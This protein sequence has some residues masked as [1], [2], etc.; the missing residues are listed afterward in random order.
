MFEF[1][2]HF[3]Y[4]V[5]RLDVIHLGPGS[6]GW[7]VP[8]TLRARRCHFRPVSLCVRFDS[9]R[10]FVARSACCLRTT[11]RHHTDSV[12][13]GQRWVLM[14]GRAS[15]PGSSILV[16][17]NYFKDEEVWLGTE[18]FRI[19]KWYYH[20]FFPDNL[21]LKRCWTLVQWSRQDVGMPRFHVRMP[22]SNPACVSSVELLMQSSGDNNWWL[23]SLDPCHP[24]GRPI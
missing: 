9:S 20:V 15:V 22:G 6:V 5:W 10:Q 16:L 1:L 13:K 2:I 11:Y 12:S 7:R 21:L 23:E 4:F 19:A 17:C 24:C 3:E 14:P 8:S 18:E